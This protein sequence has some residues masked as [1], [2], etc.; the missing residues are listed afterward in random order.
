MRKATHGCVGH[1]AQIIVETG[2]RLVEIDA[3]H[4][5]CKIR[6][7]C[8]RIQRRKAFIYLR[9]SNTVVGRPRDWPS[10]LIAKENRMPVT[11]GALRETAPNETRVSLTPEVADKLAQAGAR[12]LLEQGAGAQAN[13]PDGLYKKVEWAPSGSDVLGT[14]DIVLT[15]QPLTVEQIQQ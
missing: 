8:A 6:Q 12:V 3:N 14:S 5:R 11:I 9:I 13:F 4:G 15:V 2:V 10:S 7:F 1:D